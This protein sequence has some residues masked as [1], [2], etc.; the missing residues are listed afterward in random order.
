MWWFVIFM[1]FKT[2]TCT[3]ENFYP[4]SFFMNDCFSFGVYLMAYLL[5]GKDYTLEWGEGEDKAKNLFQKQT[6]RYMSFYTFLVEWHLV[7]L[8]IGKGLDTFTDSIACSEDGQGWIYNSS[9]GALFLMVHI[10]GTMMGTGMAR[11][12]FIKTAK[13]EGMFGGVEDK[14]SSSD[15]E[16]DKK[17]EETKKKK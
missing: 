7:E 4:D 11:A 12:V 3:K 15:D 9:K 1:A 2:T 14:D 16:G 13:A 6:E 5:H 8:V 10:I 17:K